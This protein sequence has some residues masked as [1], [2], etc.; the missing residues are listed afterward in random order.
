MI[1]HVGLV[2]WLFY[3]LTGPGGTMLLFWSGI[4]LTYVLALLSIPALRRVS[5][6]F[7]LSVLFTLG[8]E[9]IAYVFATDFILLPLQEGTVKHP[10]GY[11][12][13]AILLVSGA[14]LRAAAFARS[15][16]G[17]LFNVARRA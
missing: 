4:F 1:I 3:I 7:L 5:P 13:F 6:P 12:P 9:F 11:I 15:R 8:M 17:S 10:L 14:V 2:L 16:F